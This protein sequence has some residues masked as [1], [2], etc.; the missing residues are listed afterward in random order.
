MSVKDNQEAN[1]LDKE[2]TKYNNKD[3]IDLS[4]VTAKYEKTQTIKAGLMGHEDDG[5]TALKMTL[6]ETRKLNEHHQSLVKE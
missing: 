4:Q 5:E 3:Q 6:W 1:Q 2:I